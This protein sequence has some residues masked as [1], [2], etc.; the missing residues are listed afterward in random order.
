[1]QGQPAIEHCLRY[2]N[3]E[4][5]HL[6]PPT[7]FGRGELPKL[8]ITISRQSGCGAREVAG[9]LARFLQEQTP[10]TPAW[11][12]FD[13]DLVDKV[14]EDHHLPARF[15]RYMAEDGVFDL[16]DALDELLGA[17][18]SF[19]TF[20]QQTSETISQLA[21]LGNAIL[22]GRGAHVVTSGRTHVFH[23][24]LV[25]SLEKRVEHVRKIRSIGKE[26]A[27]AAIRRED[28]GR[29]RYL[30]KYFDKDIDDPLSYHLVVNTDSM[31]FERVAYLIGEAALK[32]FR[33][34]R[35]GERNL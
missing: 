14:L 9:H 35:K 2:I 30:K 28:R 32:N 27:L 5:L 18:P 33:V 23:V 24:R 8:T 29:K 16:L 1:M 34:E 13:H 31:C 3:S 19:W 17:H 15:A 25:S 6:P 22:I 7:L 4:S 12:V 10:S 11:N 26:E 20:V 21:E